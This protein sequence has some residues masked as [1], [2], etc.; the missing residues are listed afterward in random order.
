VQFNSQAF[1]VFFALVWAVHWLLSSQPQRT[2]LL[3]AASLFFYGWWDARFLALLLL[4]IA[5]DFACDLALGV[6]ETRGRRRAILSASLAVN[7]GVL[8]VFKYLNF[9]ADSAVGL[10]NALGWSPDRVTLELILPIGISF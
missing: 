2:R 6:T 4:S 9:F 7:L 10:L 8:G 1:L 5:V 3:V